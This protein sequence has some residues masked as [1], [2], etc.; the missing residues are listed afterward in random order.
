MMLKKKEIFHF[1]WFETYS[2][3][4]N[5]N[6][7]FKIINTSSSLSQV[8]EQVDGNKIK[9]IHSPLK[10]LKINKSKRRNNWHTF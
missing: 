1:I 4:Y 8:W 7:P 5:I 10:D 9:S 6:Y 2:I 3:P